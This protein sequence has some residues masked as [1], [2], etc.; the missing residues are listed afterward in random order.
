MENK[1]LNWNVN[2]LN[3]QKKINIIFNWIQNQK[4]NV[5][6]LQKTHI[7]DKDKKILIKKNIG[8]EFCSLIQ[9]KKRG[10]VIYIKKEL[11]PKLKFK[12]EEGRLVAVEAKLYEEKVL[13]V[14]IYASNEH[15]EF[16]FMELRH[17]LQEETYNQIILTGVFNGVID[18]KKD[19]QVQKGTRRKIRGKLPQVFH[20]I[21]KQEELTDVWRYKNPTSRDYTFYYDRHATF[22]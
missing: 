6:C 15:K 18:L 12:D 21:A 7:K 3:S 13:I 17:K 8:E 4:C 2:G 20:E 11:E 1:V 16:F 9:K 19:K 10:M 5:C 14:N 22:S